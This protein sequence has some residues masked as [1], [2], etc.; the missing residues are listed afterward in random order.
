MIHA[1]A[2]VVLSQLDLTPM[3]ER[4]PMVLIEEGAGGKFAQASGVVVIKDFVPKILESEMK[5]SGNDFDV[6][7]VI[8]VPGP[9]TDYVV[10]YTIDEP[11]RTMAGNWVKG[12][13]KASRWHWKVE[14]ALKNFSGLAQSLEDENQTITVGV[15]VSAVLAA[16]KAI[17]KRAESTK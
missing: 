3:L 5:Q 15:N 8:E 13:L 12:D 9:D 14:A 17:K 1:L 7:L 10:R 11:S 6:H 4:G 16:T 2:L